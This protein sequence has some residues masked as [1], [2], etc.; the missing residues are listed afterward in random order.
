MAE[1]CLSFG[2]EISYLGRDIECVTNGENEC[3]GD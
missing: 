3:R 2:R 1:T